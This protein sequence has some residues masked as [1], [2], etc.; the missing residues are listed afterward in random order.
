MREKTEKRG[1]RGRSYMVLIRHGIT[2]GNQKRWFYGGV[3]IPLAEEGE[4]KLAHLREKGLYPELPEDVQFFTSGMLR[5]RQTLQILY[6][7]EEDEAIPE[8]AEMRFGDFECLTYEE[9]KEDEDFL[10]WML[11]E[12]GK[13]GPRGAEPRNHFRERVH[14]GLQKLIGLHRIKEWSHRHGGEDA[15]SCV[16][17]HGGVISAMMQDMFPD[18]AAN[19]FD[20]IPDPGLGY[21]VDMKEG[22]PVGYQEITEIKKLG[23]GIMR[24]PMKDGEID[25]EQLNQMVDR[26]MEG[27]YSYFDTAFGYVNET[28]EIALGKAVVSR[29]PRESFQI[30]TKL[31]AWEVTTEEEAKQMFEVS[32][33]RLGV[34]YFDFYLMHNLG[35]NR[36]QSFR[37]FGIWEFLKEKRAS[38]EIR[39]LGFSFH[40]KASVLDSLLREYKDTDFVQLQINYAD[41]ENPRVD[42]R[43]CY[44][45]ARKYNLPIVIM[46]PVKGGLLAGKMPPDAAAV[47]QQAAPTASAASWA[48][49]FCAELPGVLTVL[50]GMSDMDQMED[51]LNTMDHFRPLSPEERQTIG[52]VVRILDSKPHVP[53]TFCRYCVAGCPKEIEIPGVFRVMNVATIY[54]DLKSASGSYGWETRNGAKAS[55]CIGCG[56]C[57]SVCPQQIDIIEQLKKAAEMFDAV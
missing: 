49:R 31:P 52:E 28:S 21:V 53:C 13:K 1:F 30:A 9:L 8:L 33:Q 44:E 39:Q 17:C 10:E 32:K 2:E 6:G 7:A 24:P 51:N 38:G 45:V 43:E 11:D 54:G 15:C 48:L 19:M 16:V 34:D 23:F 14:A 12:T 37:D 25:Q 4:K 55:H 40:D 41:W 35:G 22:E 18:V 46:E 47:L 50:S 36:T 56:Q 42:A 27:G 57:E 5:T 26:F 20:W 3:D 29:Y